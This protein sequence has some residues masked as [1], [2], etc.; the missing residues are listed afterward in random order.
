MAGF[1]PFARIY[2]DKS[3]TQE[4]LEEWRPIL[5]PFDVSMTNFFVRCSLFMPTIM[6]EHEMEYG[7]K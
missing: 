4:M 5:C 6:Y 7:Y 2:F 3:A 1:L